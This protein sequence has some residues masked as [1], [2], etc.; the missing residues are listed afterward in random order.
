MLTAF[1]QSS[2]DPRWLA[3]YYGTRALFSVAWVAA[4]F[5]AGKT[6]SPLTSALLVAYPAWDAL[7]NLYDARRNG[8]LAANPTQAFNAVVSAAV[9]VAV[10]VTMRTN[11]HAVFAVFGIW[12][13]LSGLLQLATGIRRWRSVGAQWPMIL[14]GAQSGLAGVFFVKQAA[15]GVIVPSAADIAPYAAF[16]ALYFAMSAIV[17]AISSHRAT[18]PARTA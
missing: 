9:T 12:A 7:A 17:L 4:A 13:T 10:V 15:D 14:S 1:K 3:R 11:I 18:R 6:P 2:S 5:A 16:G 8:G